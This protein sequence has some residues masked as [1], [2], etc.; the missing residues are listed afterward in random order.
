MIRMKVDIVGID[1]T[2]MLPVVILSDL[3]ESGILPLVVGPAEASAISIQMENIKTPRPLTHDL[4]VASIK[5]LHAKVLRV[6]VTDLIAD[7]YH[8]VLVLQSDGEDV[9]IDARPSDCIALALRV[10]APIFIT[11]TLAEKAMVNRP[12]DEKDEEM[13]SFRDFLDQISPDDFKRFRSD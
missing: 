10:D 9:E 4:F 2:S 1:Q 12:E 6:V 8:A 11:E 13:E 7:T 3:K 5:A